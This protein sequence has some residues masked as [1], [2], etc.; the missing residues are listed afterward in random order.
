MTI[1]Q[2]SGLYIFPINNVYKTNAKLE[3]KNYHYSYVTMRVMASEI[4]RI[5]IVYSTVCS[6]A[7]QRKHQSSGSLAFVR[8]IH[9]WPVDSMHKN[10]VMRKMFPFDDIIM[11]GVDEDIPQMMLESEDHY[12]SQGTDG[13]NIHKMKLSFLIA[14]AWNASGAASAC[15]H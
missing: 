3:T 15:S 1:Y 4:T 9:C 14:M 10:L 13:T 2:L 11:T 5:S 8:G 12:K 6:G 7:D